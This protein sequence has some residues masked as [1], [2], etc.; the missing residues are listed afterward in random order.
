MTNRFVLGG[1]ALVIGLVLGWAGHGLLGYGKTT[2]TITSYDDWRVSCPASTVA[3]QHCTIEQDTVDTKTRQPV[4]RIAI[5]TDKDKLSLVATV[6][7]GVSLPA[8][9]GFAFG[10]DAVKTMPYRV[11]AATGCIAEVALDDKLQAGFDAGKD[12]H[13]TFTFPQANAKPVQVP[14]SLKGFATAERAYRNA[15]AKRSSWF[16]R[17]F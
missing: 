2:E 9:A 14:V 8:G 12:G 17:M 7:L 4:A 15:E 10:S 3:A 16:W 11:C 6:P 1:I 13:M 5:L